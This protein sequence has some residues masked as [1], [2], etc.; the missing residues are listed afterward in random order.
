MAMTLDKLFNF[1]EQTLARK[2]MNEKK[3]SQMAADR[4]GWGNTVA[5]FGRLVDNTIGPGG[6]LGVKDPILQ[7]KALVETAFANAQRNSTEEELADPSI[8]YSKVLGEL[9]N[10]GAPAKYSMGLSKIIQDLK[11]ATLTAEGNAAYKEY[12]ATYNA[13]QA[14]TTRILKEKAQKQKRE[15]EFN[16]YFSKVGMNGERELLQAIED[17]FSG[18]NGD[19]KNRLFNE[20]KAKGSE[21]YRN[22]NITIPE[23][24][25]QITTDLN[26]SYDFDNAFLSI[27]GEDSLKPKLPVDVEKKQVVESDDL[28]ELLKTYPDT[29]KK[30]PT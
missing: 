9:K 1:D 12:T 17:Q 24:M 6:A 11:N 30:D 26:K 5:G 18:I 21:L 23:V 20:L 25:R 16:K 14:E 19:P 7:E 22:S 28:T 15:G 4:N 2:V 3:Y 8:L 27:F 29:R 10:V 13:N